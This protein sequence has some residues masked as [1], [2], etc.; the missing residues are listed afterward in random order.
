MKKRFEKLLRLRYTVAILIGSAVVLA[1]VG[2]LTYQR[3]VGTLRSGIALTDARIVTDY[4]GY[5]KVLPMNT[6][7][8][9]KCLG[10]ASPGPK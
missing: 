4:F 3:I 2:E 9:S 10:M 7:A 1:G 5:D 8:A 6:G